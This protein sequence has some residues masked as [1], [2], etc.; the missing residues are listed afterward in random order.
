MTM[1]VGK[2]HYVRCR[3]IR[4]DRRSTWFGIISALLIVALRVSPSGKSPVYTEHY[5]VIVSL[6]ELA[7]DN[8]LHGLELV[9]IRSRTSLLMVEWQSP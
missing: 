1:I 2:K 4:R 8:I 7:T 9:K 6:R 5:A 3:R